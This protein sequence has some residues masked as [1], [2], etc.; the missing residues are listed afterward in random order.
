MPGGKAVD[1][2][3]KIANEGFV[4]QILCEN[5]VGYGY[6]QGAILA[7]LDGESLVRLGGAGRQTRVDGD[8]SGPV[9]HIAPGAGIERDLPVGGDRVGAPEE[10]VVGIEDVVLP[11]G[12]LAFGVIGPKFSASAQMALCDILLGEPMIWVMFL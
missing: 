9:Q 11:V 1:A 10:H 2:V 8:D 6:G 3:F 4:P 7:R 5:G 12:P